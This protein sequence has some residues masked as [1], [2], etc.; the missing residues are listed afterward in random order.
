MPKGSTGRETNTIIQLKNPEKI[1]CDCARCRHSKKVAGT[2]YCTYYDEI[3]PERKTCA[4]YWCVK[5]S[6]PPPN[7]KKRKKPVKNGNLKTTGAAP[8]NCSQL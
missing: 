8:K 2:L 6:V 4:R 3:S 7:K 5:P 1:T